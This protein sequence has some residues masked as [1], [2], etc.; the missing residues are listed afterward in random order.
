MR[1]AIVFAGVLVA[2]GSAHIAVAD[3]VL[4]V[5]RSGIL[6][7]ARNVDVGGTFYD[8]QFVD[9]LCSS[10]FAGCD[11]ASDF[12]FAT[13]ADAAAAADALLKQVFVD[14]PGVGKF[15]THPELTL[16]CP[17][18]LGCFAAIPVEVSFSGS[19]GVVFGA[20]ADNVSNG[21]LVTNFNFIFA[22]DTTVDTQEV[23]AKFTAAE[24]VPEPA[25]L[26]LLGSGLTA[27]VALRRRV[28]AV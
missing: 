1:L 11:A 21:G 23:W 9:G 2:L 25:T 26:A 7:G 22:R 15:D 4:L 13:F 12:N 28:R 10:V 5:N 8:V 14:V 19:G 20:L 3:P 17:N 6:T 27:M 24:P 16:G 18:P